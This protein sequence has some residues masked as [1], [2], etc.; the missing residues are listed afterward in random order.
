MIRAVIFDFDGLILD[1]EVPEFQTWQEIYQA[2]GCELALEV[3][4][5]GL[6]TSAD[7]FDPYTH[8]ETQLG[9]LLDREVIQRQRRQRYQELLE[10]TS[11]LPGV[12]EYIAEAKRLGL[13]LGVASSSSREWVVGHLTELGLYAHF[14]CIKCRDDVPRVKPDPALYQAVVEVL[15]LQPSQAIALEDSPNG[16]AAAKRAGLFCIAVPNQ[17]TCQLP[18]EQ[19]DLQL[20]SLAE[21][22]LQQLLEQL[23][24]NTWGAQRER[25]EQARGDRCDDH[26]F[27]YFRGV[28]P[29]SHPPHRWARRLHH[30]RDSLG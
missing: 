5:T 21:L 7:A 18:L 13:H 8:L 6:G 30:H 15:A 1:T 17:L 22:P 14:D 3:W 10:A 16:I 4:A 25:L 19:A 23:Q 20:R 2:H 11:V 24:Q 28:Y 27:P 9:R 12:R 26:S 29:V